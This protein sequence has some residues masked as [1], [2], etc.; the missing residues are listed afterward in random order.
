MTENTTSFW[1]TS[2]PD[3]DTESIASIFDK[4]LIEVD[5]QVLCEYDGIICLPT[6]GI[7]NSLN[8][9]TCVGIIVWDMLRILKRS[10]N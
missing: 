8:V 7:K 2:I 10:G 6:C 5:V 3:D 1:G 4:K 9:T